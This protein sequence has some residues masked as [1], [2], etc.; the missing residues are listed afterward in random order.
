MGRIQHRT[1]LLNWEKMHVAQSLQA[2]F[3]SDANDEYLRAFTEGF[4]EGPH[5]LP[6]TVF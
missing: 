4:K 5:Y 1:Q 3:R 2:V 6:I